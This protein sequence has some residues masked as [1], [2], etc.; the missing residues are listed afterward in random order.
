MRHVALGA[1]MV[2]GV[3]RGPQR[4]GVRVAPFPGDDRKSQHEYRESHREPGRIGGAMS[5]SCIHRGALRLQREAP[6]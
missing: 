2:R 1:M 4:R 3:G 5:L 6:I